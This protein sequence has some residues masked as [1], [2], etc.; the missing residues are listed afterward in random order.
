MNDEFHILNEDALE[1]EPSI[2]VV[3]AGGNGAQMVGALARLHLALIGLGRASGI[4]HVTVIDDDV[5][6]EA[7]IGRQIWSASD[8]GKNKARVIVNRINAY[9][10]LA[11]DAV[12]MKLT[13]RSRLNAS[14]NS[15]LIL[16]GC[17]DSRGARRA[18]H[19]VAIDCRATY[20]LDLGNEEHTGQVILGEP[21][22]T[23]RKT[24][25]QMPRL[26]TVTE[27]FPQLMDR[28]IKEDDRPSCSVAISLASQG[29]FIND[30]AV[31]CA[32]Q[33]LYML[34]A[35]GR[36]RVHGAFFDFNSMRMT[37]APIQSA[38]WRRMGYEPDNGCRT[39]AT[40]ALAA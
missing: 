26:P 30:L 6:S 4:G 5:V 21:P 20:Y 34:F 33:L 29:L 39:R 2:V 1:R 36:M 11:W 12:A 25:Q 32:A 24:S 17:V 23:W 31:R 40:Q 14:R 18:I 7:N 10:G 22:T 8:I 16:I 15:P 13:S 9:Y 3:G 38:F 35:K 19:K 27:L 37:P 28:S